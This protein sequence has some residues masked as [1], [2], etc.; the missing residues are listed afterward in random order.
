MAKA[1][2]RA[3]PQML[4]LPLF[5]AAS[6]LSRHFF[7]AGPLNDE[8]KDLPALYRLPWL[9]G[10]SHFCFQGNDGWLSHHG[11]SRYAWDF[12]MPVGTPIPAARDGVVALVVDENDGHGRNSP[13]NEIYIDHGDG[14]QARYAHIKKAGAKVKVGEQVRQGQMIAYS[15]DVGRSLG[16]HLH[17]EVVTSAQ[18]IPSTDP[19]EIGKSSIPARFLDVEIHQGVPRS[20]Y[21]YT[22][23]N[24]SR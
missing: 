9:P 14:T 1:R 12:L 21:F 20:T 17:F 5:V 23:R 6:L 4:A 15:G 2:T 3:K 24:I 13:N 16:P 10:E 18:H 8:G 11:R 7:L 19:A 22:S